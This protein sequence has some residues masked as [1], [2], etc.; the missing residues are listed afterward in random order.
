M[1][2]SIRSEL[3]VERL[4]SVMSINN[5]LMVTQEEINTVAPNDIANKRWSSHSGYRLL[6]KLCRTLPPPAMGARLPFFWQAGHV[7]GWRCSS[8]SNKPVCI[9]YICYK[10]IHVR[11]QISIMF[12]RIEHWVHLRSSG[13]RQA[14][15]TDTRTCH[16]YR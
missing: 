3:L 14:Q 13:I 8:N 15:C 12:N 1:Y 10:Q 4:K 7:D 16:L 5:A 11:K 2:L 6:C 9:C